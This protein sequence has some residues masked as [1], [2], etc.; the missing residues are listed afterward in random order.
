VKKQVLQFLRQ[1]VANLF[2]R[3]YYHSPDSWRMNRFMGYPILQYPGDLQIYQELIHATRPAFVVQTGV[4]NGGSLL[5]FASILDLIQAPAS[6]L[7]VG[8]DLMLTERAKTLHHPRIRLIEGSSTDAAVV[9]RVREVLPAPRGGLVS[10][11]S[12]HRCDHVLAE[13]RTYQDLVSPGGYLVAEDTNVNGRPISRRHGPGPYE[14]VEKFLAEQ[15]GFVRDDALWRRQLFSFH[16]FGW[17]KRE[18]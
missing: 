11:D 1:S 14:A 8:V 16:Q 15:R 9:E 18:R 12:D 2:H 3:A 7:V 5:Y 4:A 17:L 13:L 10:L 6:A